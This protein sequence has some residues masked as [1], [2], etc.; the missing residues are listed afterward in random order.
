MVGRTEV[1]VG[2]IRR[3][4]VVGS[5]VVGDNSQAMAE[6][7]TGNQEVGSM[8]VD[9]QVCSQVEDSIQDILWVPREVGLREEVDESQQSQFLLCELYSLY[10]R[11]DNCSRI[12]IRRRAW[13]HYPV[14]LLM[15]RYYLSLPFLESL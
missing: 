4:E 12:R 1:E 8:V 11:D 9:T 13:N 10:N 15:Y 5:M 2:D 6:V 7:G 14:S 3:A